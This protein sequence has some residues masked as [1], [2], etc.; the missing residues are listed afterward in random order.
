MITKKLATNPIQ[1]YS[2]STIL[3]H[4]K[5]PRENCLTVDNH[6]VLCLARTLQDTQVIKIDFDNVEIDCSIKTIITK[7]TSQNE[8]KASKLQD[9][10]EKLVAQN[11]QTNNLE[12]IT[13]DKINNLDMEKYLDF[14]QCVNSEPNTKGYIFD[15]IK[16]NDCYD[17]PDIIN[18]INEFIASLPSKFNTF[19]NDNLSSLVAW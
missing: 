10:F 4:F 8:T 6:G 18:K 9:T 7:A 2:F 14:I 5:N 12:F 1:K 3:Q 19:F 13:P 17:Y 16:K 11:T 15:L